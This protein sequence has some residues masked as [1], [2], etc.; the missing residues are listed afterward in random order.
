MWW[1]KWQPDRYFYVYFG[2]PLSVKFLHWFI[3]V[4][5]LIRLLPAVQVDKA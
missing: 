2:F 4:F 5:I 1:I 3:F